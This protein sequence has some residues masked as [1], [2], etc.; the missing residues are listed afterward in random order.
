M[1]TYEYQCDA[2]SER[3]EKF[4]SITAAPIKKCPKCG[5]KKVRRLISSGAGILFKGSGFYITDYRD[6][7]YKDK[8]KAESGATSDTKSADTKPVDA[9]SPDVTSTDTK[10]TDAKPAKA[11]EP[12]PAQSASRS[13][14]KP[15][16]KKHKK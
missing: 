6:A 8:A 11:A 9:K 10:S 3:F 5:K 7:S 1:P 4:Q 16:S 12:K 14:A 2:C 13:A 15:V